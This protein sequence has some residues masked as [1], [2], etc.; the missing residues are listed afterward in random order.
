MGVSTAAMFTNIAL[1]C[2]R[3]QQFDMV[4]ACFLKALACA[5]TDD[6]LAEIWYNIGE[7]A[8][9]Q[10]FIINFL[11][12]YYFLFFFILSSSIQPISI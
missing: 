6:E 10:I 8:L 4:I 2:F 12:L 5:T 1:S 11:F 3:A 7:I 9:V